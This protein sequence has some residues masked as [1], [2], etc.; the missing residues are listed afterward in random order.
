MKLFTEP[1]KS[2]LADVLLQAPVIAAPVAVDTVAVLG[3]ALGGTAET[4]HGASG[5]HWGALSPSVAVQSD[6]LVVCFAAVGLAF[7]GLAP[8]AALGGSSSRLAAETS[9]LAETTTEA[10]LAEATLVETT[11][12]ET[13]LAETAWAVTSMSETTLAAESTAETWADVTTRWVASA[14]EAAA[15]AVAS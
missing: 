9:V 8:V 7:W 13:T 4:S 2:L 5:P 6:G 1:A 12:S 3:A 15:W 10:A 14:E 11:M